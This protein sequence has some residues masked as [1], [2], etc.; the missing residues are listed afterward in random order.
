MRFPSWRLAIAAAIATASAVAPR[1]QTPA[2]AADTITIRAGQV[3]DGRGGVARDI[4]IEVAG[5]K[6]ARVGRGSGRATYELPSLTV[7]PGWIDT[8]VHIGAH[9]NKSGRY[10]TQNETP[11]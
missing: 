1:A 9:F 8:H 10:D 6:I 4:L 2:P 3:F 5:G 11:A 7:M